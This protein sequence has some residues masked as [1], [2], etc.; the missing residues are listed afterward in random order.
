MHEVNYMGRPQGGPNMVCTKFGE[1]WMK[2]V[3]IRSQ[4]YGNDGKI[5]EVN[6]PISSYS[7]SSTE[8][9]ETRISLQCV[10]FAEILNKTFEIFVS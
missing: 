1:D 8:S 2:Y 5:F 4:K 7:A 6:G 9:I 10:M 3:P